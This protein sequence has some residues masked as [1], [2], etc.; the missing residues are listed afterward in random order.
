MRNTTINNK[1]FSR[2]LSKSFFEVSQFLL[3]LFEDFDCSLRNIDLIF[4]TIDHFLVLKTF[5]EN[6][7]RRT[8]LDFL[9]NPGIL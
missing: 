9:Q 7:L 1:H 5:D 6:F 4:P 3:G 2:N 8:F